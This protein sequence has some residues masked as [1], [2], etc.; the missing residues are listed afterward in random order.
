MKMTLLVTYLVPFLLSIFLLFAEINSVVLYPF[1]VLEIV[2]AYTTVL[3]YTD[4]F[5]SYRPTTR[6]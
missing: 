3:V 5:K 4:F 1:C 6:I 2:D